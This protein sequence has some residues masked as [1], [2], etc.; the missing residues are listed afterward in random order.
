MVALQVSA[1]SYKKVFARVCEG[2]IANVSGVIQKVIA[3][4][5][6]G[7]IASVSDVI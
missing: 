1:V 4:V 7:G 5:S 3:S 2:G 6:D